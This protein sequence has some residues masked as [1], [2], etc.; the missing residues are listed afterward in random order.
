[1]ALALQQS[2]IA[3]P[4]DCA[5]CNLSYKQAVQQ[6]GHSC[7]WQSYLGLAAVVAGPPQSSAK[8]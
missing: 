7:L 5:C 1:M 8:L 4:Q 6:R 2:D 3:A